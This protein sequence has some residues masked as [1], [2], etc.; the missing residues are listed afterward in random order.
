MF[1]AQGT[2]GQRHASLRK[3]GVGGCGPGTSKTPSLWHR[4]AWTQ[5][6]MLYTVWVTWTGYSVSLGVWKV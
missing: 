4:D 2:A 6:G 1:Q 3:R 5:S